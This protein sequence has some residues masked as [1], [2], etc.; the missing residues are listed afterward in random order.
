VYQIVTD[1]GIRKGFMVT[2]K[3]EMAKRF[4]FGR[5]K[6][7]NRIKFGVL[8]ITVQLKIFLV[9][10]SFLGKRGLKGF[11]PLILGCLLLTSPN[12]L[13]AQLSDEPWTFGE[14]FQLTTGADDNYSPA[15]ASNGNLYFA[16]WYKKTLSGFNVYGARIDKDGKV[17]EDDRGGVPICQPPANRSWDQIFPSVSWNGNNFFVVWQDRRSGRRW[18]I[19][20][21]RVATFGRFLSVRDPE[22]IQISIGRSGYDQVG[23]ALAFDGENYLVVW[24]GK[25]TS[26]VWSIYC[27]F[28]KVTDQEVT[29]GEDTIRVSAS[30]KDQASP[31]V[32]YNSDAGNY[33]IVWQDK[34]QGKFWDIY[35]ARIASDGTPVDDPGD[36]LISR[37][38]FN[39]WNPVL[40]WNGKYYLVAWTASPAGDNWNIYGKMFD[41]EG[42][43]ENYS[44]ILLQGDGVSKTSP[45]ILA[46]EAESILVWEEN[47]EGNSTISGA[48]IVPEYRIFT[49]EAK[50]ISDS[51]ETDAVFPVLASNG[52]DVLVVWQAMSPEG[53]WGIYGRPLLK[54][55]I[56]SD[57]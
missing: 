52:H 14:S 32:I 22:G 35:G 57:N 28:V 50:Q 19:Y 44:D 30:S 41:S 5:E 12:G 8:Y 31:S 21:A 33:F 10:A 17:F 45:A 46:G 54:A 23:P 27:K 47:P 20:G 24:R 49:G 39:Q 4:S 56:G 11:F 26:S 25:R 43:P 3:S 1:S 34:R 37:S 55:R 29:V 6:L 36:I 15:I 42:R 16:V 9:G 53:Y 51:Q 13:W 38:G 7:I 48:V 40:S 18:D 2:E